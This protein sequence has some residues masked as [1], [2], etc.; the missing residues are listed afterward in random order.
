VRIKIFI[1]LCVILFPLLAK[2]ETLQVSGVVYPDF[3]RIVFNAASAPTFQTSLSGGNLQIVF[4]SPIQANFREML[5]TL[6]GQVASAS[7]ED[8]GKRISIKLKNADVRLRKFRGQ[9]FFGVDLVPQKKEE[10][11]PVEAAP[12][13]DP[14]KEAA[15][16][17]KAKK[18]EQQKK[19]LAAKEKEKAKA[20]LEA[21]K[22]KKAEANKKEKEKKK[23]E[24]VKK[25]PEPQPT[26]EVAI[27]PAV[28]LEKVKIVAPPVMQPEVRTII[29]KPEDVI[30]VMP[31]KATKL[32]TVPW[33]KLVSVAIY[34]RGENLWVVFDG[35]AQVALADLPKQYISKAEQMPDRHSTILRLKLQPELIKNADLI[36]AN[37]EQNNW[38]IYYGKPPQEKP[39]LLTTPEENKANG[40]LISGI[41]IIFRKKN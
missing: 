10:K 1:L 21:E 37:R 29:Q 32:L 5:K 23:S 19:I 40:I 14:K 31:I 28:S 2:A 17:E 26:K 16:I 11:K 36:W 33:E 27:K 20:K 7:L 12:A 38:I 41:S 34:L 25:K 15:K 18:E 24:E 9:S 4:A 3:T 39:I 6:H 30:R 8:G 13:K 35:S 22:K